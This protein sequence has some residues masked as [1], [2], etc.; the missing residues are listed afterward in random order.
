MAVLTSLTQA[1]GSSGDTYLDPATGKQLEI[2]KVIADQEYIWETLRFITPV[3]DDQ[4]ASNYLQFGNALIQWG[5][6]STGTGIKTITFPQA[7]ANTDYVVFTQTIR[8][9]LDSGVV[10]NANIANKTTT[11]FQLNAVFVTPDA[12]GQAGEATQWIAFGDLT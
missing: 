9:T 6:G 5:I 4:S 10:I 3:L 1:G 12:V 2:A 7:F 8:S 11:T